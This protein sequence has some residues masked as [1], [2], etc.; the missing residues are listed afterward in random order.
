MNESPLFSRAFD[1]AKETC[2]L[3]ESFPRS[4]RAVLGRR[5]EEAAFDFHAAIAVAAGAKDPRPRLAAA[6]EAL[7]RHRFC[8]RLAGEL[9]L[10]SEGRLMEIARVEAECGRLLGGWQRKLDAT[11]PAR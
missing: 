2:R 7:V 6:D 10:L 11:R 4:R 9:G 5:L 3:V 1:L 8:L